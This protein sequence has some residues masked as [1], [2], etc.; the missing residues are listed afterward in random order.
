ML[1][2]HLLK[3]NRSIS[4]LI[5]TS[6]INNTTGFPSNAV[7]SHLEYLA[8][9]VKNLH[10]ED[11]SPCNAEMADSYNPPKYGPAF[12]F[13]NHSQQIR[14]MRCFL[15]YNERKKNLNFDDA[16]AEVCSKIF[17]QVSKTGMTY[18]F[19]WFCP[20]HGHCLGF[21]TIPGSERRKDP[22]AVL[23]I[24]KEL[25]PK[26]VFYDHGCSLSEYVKNRESG[27]FKN[28]RFY[29]DIFYGFTHKCSPA[30]RCSTLNGFE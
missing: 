13:Q 10:N 25:P 8:T 6:A 2:N 15:I 27:F 9:A 1:S 28:T 21:H 20:D 18:L 30:L 5:S 16:P 7:L 14:K 19:I 22:A 23:Y 24:H 29:H 17:P 26:I 12:Y 3:Y 4:E 11:V